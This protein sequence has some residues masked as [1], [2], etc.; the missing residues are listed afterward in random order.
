MDWK[1]YRHGIGVGV[2]PE[3][4]GAHPFPLVVV[5]RRVPAGASLGRLLLHD[6]DHCTTTRRVSE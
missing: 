3:L 6:L 4:R 2:D 5:V 1:T